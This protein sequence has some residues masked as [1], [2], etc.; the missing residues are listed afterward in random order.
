MEENN[1]K[2]YEETSKSQFVNDEAKV[3]EVVGEDGFS[4]QDKEDNKAMAILCYISF[5]ALIP[6][7]VEKK[8][9]WVRFNAVQGV[10]I[11]ILGLIG[12]VIAIIPFLGWFA[13][14][15]ISMFVLAL[16]IIGIVNVCNNQAKEL[17]FMDKIKFVRE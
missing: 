7:I 4:A 8:S 5:L 12:S 17:P 14:F 9:K 2:N 15:I 16:R 11:L 3:G 1:E 6:Y 10:N 13:S